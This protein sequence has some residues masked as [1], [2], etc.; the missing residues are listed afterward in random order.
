M[1]LYRWIQGHEVATAGNISRHLS[2]NRGKLRRRYQDLSFRMIDDV[3]VLIGVEPKIDRHRGTSCFEAGKE[4]FHHLR[5]VVHQQGDAGS[6]LQ[7]QPSQSV[8]QLVHSRFE[9]HIGPALS[10][11]NQ[12]VSIGVGS[13]RLRQ[14]L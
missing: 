13:S 8:G 3:G 7:T 14:Q 10:T 2:D 12:G 11:E 1:S 5:T 9:F 4:G 6:E